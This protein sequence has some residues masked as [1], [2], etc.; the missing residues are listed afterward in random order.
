VKI[1][2]VIGCGVS[3][4]LLEEN[5]GGDGGGSDLHAATQHPAS[6]HAFKW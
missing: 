2:S 5:T 3:V 6:T 1:I 4:V